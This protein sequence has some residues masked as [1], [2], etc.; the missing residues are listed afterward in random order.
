MTHQPEES[1]ASQR[2]RLQRTYDRLPSTVRDHLQNLVITHGPALIH[3]ASDDEILQLLEIRHAEDLVQ[4]IS[5]QVLAYVSGLSAGQIQAVLPDLLHLALRVMLAHF[6]E[7]RALN[8]PADGWHILFSNLI[9]RAIDLRLAAILESERQRDYYASLGTPAEPPTTPDP[10]ARSPTV[11]LESDP[12]LTPE[13]KV[14]VLRNALDACNRRLIPLF[15][16][17]FRT[18]CLTYHQRS[19]EAARRFFAA[20]PGVTAADLTEIVNSCCEVLEQPLPPLKVEDP[21]KHLR[22]ARDLSYLL[23]Q[24]RQVIK[25]CP[26]THGTITRFLS[27]QELFGGESGSSNASTGVPD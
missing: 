14:N 1:F 16:G 5:P 25:E 18:N 3:S 4:V 20:N 12:T 8:R 6:I 10:L 27:K 23:L 9:G 13:V 11:E 7:S 21:F 17:Q 19:L 26:F 24:L 2:D 15:D 22:K